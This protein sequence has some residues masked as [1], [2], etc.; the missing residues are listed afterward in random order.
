[1][2]IIR[3]DI[4]Q[5]KRKRQLLIAGVMLVILGG[6]VALLSS[7]PALPKV[8][9]EAVWVDTVEEGALELRVRGIGSLQP[10]EVRWLTAR[11]NGRVE[12]LVRLP[13]AAIEPGDVIL[14]LSNPE[15]QQE[16]TQGRLQLRVAEADYANLQAE[17]ENRLLEQ[18]SNLARVEASFESAQLE[19]EVNQELFAEGLVAAL[20]ARQSD[21]AARQFATQ[22]ELEK[23][24]LAS[25]RN[26]VDKQLAAR[27]VSVEQEQERFNLLQS[28][29]EQLTLRATMKGILQRLPV[30]E[31]EQVSAGQNLAQVSDPLKLK[32]VIR[33]PETQA[34]DVVNGQ[35]AE[36]D[37]RNG[38]VTGNVLRVSPTVENGTVD[39]EISL[40][41]ELP[42]GA[43]PDLTVEGAIKLAE[44][45]DVV[46]VGRPAFAGEN[47]SVGMF[48]LETGGA[49]AVRVPV[50][51]GP[52][53]VTRIVVREGLQAGDQVI[54][55]DT[56]KW[57]EFD[58][59]Q[60]Q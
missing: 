4:R 19:A 23:Q 52:S 15:L 47:A 56:S 43:R 20:T 3:T 21:L 13:G 59:I 24:R 30:V 1:M 38:L 42:R 55:S 28:Q 50:L 48:K 41:G 8:D 25:L 27:R 45:E 22:L 51:F 5:R 33:I 44:L 7:E 34:R 40:P 54:L 9:R 14:H 46:H 16:L 39:V 60:L 29:V 12:Q 11:T 2:D 53:S 6:L 18:R 57:D 26:A 17:L 58:R 31:G 36:I 10:V 49:T 32:A 37:T 35:K